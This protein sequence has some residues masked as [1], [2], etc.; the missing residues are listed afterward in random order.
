[1]PDL[2]SSPYAQVIDLTSKGQREKREERA[3]DLFPEPDPP[4][5]E[6][7]FDGL[8]D[9]LQQAMRAAGWTELMEVQRRAVPYILDG[10]DLIVQSRT[11][12]GKTGAFL[13]PL[14]QVL[15][16]HKKETQALVL[17]PTR[18]L[19][20]QVHHEFER[21]SAATPE[22]YD[23]S[24][25]LIYGGVKYGPQIRA[26][27][28][29]AQV[30]IGTPGRILDHIGRNNLKLGSLRVFILDEADEMLSM[31]F[32]PSMKKIKR[33]LPEERQSYMFSA[34]MPPK[35]RSLGREFLT[36]PGFLMLSSGNISVDAIE[37]RY[38]L[39]KPQEKDRALI[40]LIEMENPESALVF[41][42]TKREVSYLTQ[43][44]KNYGHH[45]DE[46]SG[47]LS[48]KDREKA[49]GRIREGDLRFL[50]AT[51]VAARGIDISDLSHVFVY[52]VPQDP[53]YYVHRS[54]RTARAGKTGTAIA[55]ATI[56]DRH[57][58]ES[59]SRRY[60]FEIAE[61]ELPTE[62]EVATRIA[63]RMTVVLEERMRQKS[64]LERERLERFVP[65]VR[66]LSREEPELLAMLIDEIYHK[67]MHRPPEQPKVD[68]ADA[69]KDGQS[70]KNKQERG[71]K[72]TSKDDG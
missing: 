54:G 69:K 40:R 39:V 70:E 46:I 29:G 35:V 53:E 44:L 14:F 13:L 45:A 56:E 48:Q 58:I 36:D 62:E 25:A 21:M 42:N 47:D 72:K 38:Y 59:I 34:T 18:E 30:V 55:L 1:M 67:R 22:T 65:V 61:H 3:K 16:P 68:G 20:K 5:P 23:L 49:M 41:A 33:H 60:G 8:P 43:F 32:Y 9:K 10:R 7:T 11:G 64:N 57:R 19:A 26:L 28:A 2:S 63:E 4:L 12:S 51:D 37:H 50:V 66:E 17:A 71:E 24:T 6:A 15:D 52:D 31:G 27:K